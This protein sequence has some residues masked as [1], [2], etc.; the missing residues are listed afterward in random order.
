VVRAATTVTQALDTLTSF[1]DDAGIAYEVVAHDPTFT[2][3]DEAQAA[4]IDPPAMAKT[5]VLHDEERFILAA[6]PASRTLDL[7]RCRAALGA[8]P[9]LRLAAEDEIAQA[10][11]QFEVGAIPPL[12]VDV[13]EVVDVRLLYRERIGCAAGDHSHSVLIDPR[14]LVRLAEPRVADICEHTGHGSR[15]HDLP[16]V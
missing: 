2:A 11:G 14:D 6:I 10:F 12:G 9:H 4:H 5:I 7:N 15:F 3:Q 8:S 13:P 16:K 1:L